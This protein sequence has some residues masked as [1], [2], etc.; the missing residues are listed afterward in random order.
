MHA[1]GHFFNTRVLVEH[2]TRR[3]EDD[4]SGVANRLRLVQPDEET[5]A[6]AQLWKN[7][8]RHTCTEL[9]WEGECGGERVQ[10]WRNVAAG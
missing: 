3:A 9:L 1:K 2:E 7:L 8:L 10:V 4:F 6:K 5:F